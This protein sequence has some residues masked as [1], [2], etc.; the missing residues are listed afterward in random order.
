MHRAQADQAAVTD[1]HPIGPLQI[2]IEREVHR[3]V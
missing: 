1:D 3:D 2:R